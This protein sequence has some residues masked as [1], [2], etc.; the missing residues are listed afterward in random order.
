MSLLPLKKR[1]APAPV[2]EPVDE[3]VDKPGGKNRPTPKRS[4]A[5]AARGQVTRT[6]A[7]PASTARDARTST[8]QERRLQSAEQRQAML[9]GDVAKMPAYHRA[10][11]R[12]YARELVDKRRNIGPLF[13]P[14]AVLCLFLSQVR[15]PAIQLAG[16][17][18]LY[19]M[20]TIL[21]VDAFLLG[22]YV[23]KR[24]AEKF[25]NSRVPVRMYSFQR[26][27]MPKRWRMPRPAG[28]TR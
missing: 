21:I 22:R 4:E 18:A 9:T 2:D 19:I 24:V 1:S 25:P 13:L 3:P 23:N 15:V 10:P 11:E 26:S 5:R 14:V 20:M 7:S 28:Y 17:V 16:A 8:R 6:P 27:I 12:V